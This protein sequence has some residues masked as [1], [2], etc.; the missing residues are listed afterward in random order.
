MSTM[1]AETMDTLEGV[2]HELRKLSDEYHQMAKGYG[3][4]S[5]IGN[6]RRRCLE[7][8]DVYAEIA[9]MLERMVERHRSISKTD[10]AGTK[11]DD[12]EEC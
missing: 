2:A 8:A 1:S 11:A 12:L 5:S 7:K 6:G 10:M 3:L 4:W 9:K